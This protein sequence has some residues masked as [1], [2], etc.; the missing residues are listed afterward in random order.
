[1]KL[2][3]NYD[4]WNALRN[5]REPLTP[6]KVERNNRVLTLS[7]IPMTLFAYQFTQYSTLEVFPIVGVNYLFIIGTVYCIDEIFKRLNLKERDGMDNY[8]FASYQKL[9][10]LPSQ[11]KQIHVKTTYPMLLESELY[12]HKKR[13]LKEEGKIPALVDEKYIMVPTLNYGG[14]KTETSILQE[15][16]IGSDLYSLSIGE[17]QKKMKKVL[18]PNAI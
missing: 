13:I 1:M 3:I 8:A 14:G 18:V 4:F 16:V 9:K 6:M 7:Y 10:T 2:S 12:D 5:V 15:H 11:L 17:P